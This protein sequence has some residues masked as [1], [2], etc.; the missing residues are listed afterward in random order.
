V[1]GELVT[2]PLAEV[3]ERYREIEPRYLELA[4]ILAR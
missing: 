3:I 1:D 2:F 4:E